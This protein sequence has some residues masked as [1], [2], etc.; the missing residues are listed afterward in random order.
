MGLGWQDF[1]ALGIVF[2][3][4][5][6]LTRLCLGAFA[7]KSAMGC[8]SGCGKCAGVAAPT[9]ETGPE[10]QLQIVTIGS[11]GPVPV[12]KRAR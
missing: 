9:G 3:A 12:P 4:L 5:A 6:Y 2:A 1:V 10:D 8:N 7:R 11:I